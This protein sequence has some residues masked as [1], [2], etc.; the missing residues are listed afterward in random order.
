M[1]AII[2]AAGTVTRLQGVFNQPKCL[3]DIGGMPLLRRYLESFCA[4]GIEEVVL[5]LGYK[6][7]KVIDYLETLHPGLPVHTIY[8]ENY[9]KGSILS[10][11]MARDWL[12]GDV[13]LMDGDVYFER[14]FLMTAANSKKG[15]FFLLDSGAENDGEAVMVGLNNGNAVS[16][17]R[18]LQGNFDVFGEWAGAL[19]LSFK[20]SSLLREIVCREVE[21]GNIEEGYEFIVPQLFNSIDLSF[22]LVDGLKR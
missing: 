9:Q 14:E 19:R 4:I 20:G 6:S 5:V 2:L 7:E 10:L 11:W 8:N 21:Q 3:I 13:L 1:N 22:E 17:E 16:L 12:R 15:N 18:G